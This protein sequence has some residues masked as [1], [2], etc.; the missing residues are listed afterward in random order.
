[1]AVGS[2][3]MLARVRGAVVGRLRGDVPQRRRPYGYDNGHNRQ[4][5][6]SARRRGRLAERIG[7]STK[8]Q[9]RQL[10]ALSRRTELP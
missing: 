10:Y 3:G 1:M 6:W 2:H 9:V 7:G 8:R 5:G 4:T